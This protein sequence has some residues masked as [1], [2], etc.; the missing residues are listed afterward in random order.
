MSHQ[1]AQGTQVPS[2][3]I[4][5]WA[6]LIKHLVV[7]QGPDWQPGRPWAHG[8]TIAAVAVGLPAYMTRSDHGNVQGRT[9]VDESDFRLLSPQQR[10]IALSSL[11]HDD[12]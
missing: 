2:L 12:G 8:C 3:D 6:H 4:S 9:V 10:R 1:Q 7:C 11:V 5:F